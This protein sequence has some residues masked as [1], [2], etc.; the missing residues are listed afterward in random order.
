MRL[1][2]RVG[3]VTGAGRNSIT[4]NVIGSGVGSDTI[5]EGGRPVANLLG[6]QGMPPDIAGAAVF[7]VSDEADFITGADLLVDGGNSAGEIPRVA[8]GRQR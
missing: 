6:R 2:N 4:P 1:E 5:P 3:I 7:L 8:G